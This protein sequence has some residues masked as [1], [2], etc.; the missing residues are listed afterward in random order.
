MISAFP[1]NI[2]EQVGAS[3]DGDAFTDTSSLNLVRAEKDPN[4]PTDLRLKASLMRLPYVDER[5]NDPEIRDWMRSRQLGVG[6]SEIAVLFGLSPWQTLEE[7]WQEKVY[8]CEFDPGSELF[9]W[10]HTMEPVIAA[11]FTRRTGQEVALPPEMIMVGTKNHY[12]ASLDRV[13]IENGE[14]IAALEL[15]N[16]NDSRYGEYKAGGPSVGYLLQLQ[17]QM[18]VAGL[19]HGYLAV[20]FG[21]QRW[22]CWR[23][24]A[25][26]SVQKEI[27]NR[28]DDFWSYVQSK[29]RPPKTL[30]VRGVAEPD[31]NALNLTD[32][33]WEKRLSQ[34]NTLRLEKTA[35]E[36]EEKILKQQV[37]EVIGDCTTASAGRMK[38][39]MSYSTRKQFD[40]KQ[41]E[42]D[43]PE[44]IDRYTRTTEVGTLRIRNTSQ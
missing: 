39:S 31:I 6:A 38:A 42:T 10:G 14:A 16:L 22:A 20:M 33:E 11:E 30:G 3:V 2:F 43:H 37:K 44:L 8:G 35:I 26:P 24:L 28:V 12:R 27:F 34:L 23:V 32:P 7:L 21:G 17:Y 9:H 13:V 29:E 1:K 25:S 5:V 18:A 40:R 41:L 36:K 15:K 4:A 19:D